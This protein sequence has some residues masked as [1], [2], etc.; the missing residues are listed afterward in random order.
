[1]ANTILLL[2][3]LFAFSLSTIFSFFGWY[4][5]KTIFGIQWEWDLDLRLNEMVSSFHLENVSF[6]SFIKTICTRIHLNAIIKSQFKLNLKIMRISVPFDVISNWM[7]IFQRSRRANSSRK[8][9]KE[10][11]AVLFCSLIWNKIVIKIE[12]KVLF[13]CSIGCRFFPFLWFVSNVFL[14]WQCHQNRITFS[15]HFQFFFSFCF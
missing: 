6:S 9:K 2:H 1:M 13:I 3:S 12:K 14:L 11:S 4:Y 5:Y 7:N 10:I 15:L 8:I